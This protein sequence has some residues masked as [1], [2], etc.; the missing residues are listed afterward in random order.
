MVV[1]A[2]SGKDVREVLEEELIHDVGYL[3]KT[4]GVGILDSQL[5]PLLANIVKDPKL[6]QNMPAD[7]AREQGVDEVIANAALACGKSIAPDTVIL[8]A[9]MVR[10]MLN[11]PPTAVPS[12]AIALIKAVMVPNS[13]NFA[14]M[15]PQ[16]AQNRFREIQMG[17]RVGQPDATVAMFM[18]RRA[19]LLVERQKWVDKYLVDQEKR[20]LN[21]LS[22]PMAAG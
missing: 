15:N 16:A 10:K 22:H 20:D 12:G 4:K 21:M 6:L 7:L 14:Y 18:L 9:E 17:E 2:Q 1:A 8:D 13:R 5:R 3:I 19:Q 11:A